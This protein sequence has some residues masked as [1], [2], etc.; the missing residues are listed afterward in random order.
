M[1][2]KEKR[3]KRIKKIKE[4]RK[5]LMMD[6]RSKGGTIWGEKGEGEETNERKGGK[7]EKDRRKLGR[8]DL[9]KKVGKRRRKRR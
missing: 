2:K 1:K 8:K 3:K 4:G 5:E 7:E 9:G 6:I